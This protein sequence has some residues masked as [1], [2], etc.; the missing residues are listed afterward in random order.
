MSQNTAESSAESKHKSATANS[1]YLLA[2]LVVACL[3]YFLLWT[4]GYASSVCWTGAVTCLCACWWISE[5]VPIPVT[6]LVPLALLPTTGVLT[7]AQVGQAYGSPTVLLVMGG[8]ILSA[9]MVSSGAHQRVAL[10]MVNLFGG[11][12]SRRIVFGFMA[13]ATVLS[14]WI[15][16]AATSLMLLP[17]ILAVLETSRDP[18]LATPLL[19][20]LAYAANV[21]GLGTPIGTPANLVFIQVYSD[22]TGKDIGFMQ[23]MVWGV[24]IILLFLPLIGFWLTRKLHY[25][26]AIELPEVGHWRVEEKRVMMVFFA[27]ACAWMFRTEPLGGWSQALNVPGVT[28]ASIA[29]FA[30]I[31]LFIIPDG[32]GARLLDWEGVSKIPWGILILLGSGFAIARAFSESGLSAI[33]G[34]ALSGLTAYPILIMTAGLCLMVT[35]LTELTS[36]TATT[37]LLM[38][39]LAGAALAANIDPI[40]LMLPAALSASCAFMLP[41]ATTPNGVAFSTGQFAIKTMAREG[42]VI[43]LLGVLIIS[44]ICFFLLN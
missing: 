31:S 29:L 22:T 7:P 14:M 26:G 23:W 19:L 6:A 24:P 3:C 38:P 21:G 30:A 20:G 12:S 32:K 37:A 18:K 15:S 40:L 9:S 2:G 43:N 16:N 34:Q 41:T 13:A 1:L 5:A 44:F 42:V 10:I 4:L 28:D 39:V 8:F 36:N 11:Q 27:T 33:L 17:V 25:S 35:F